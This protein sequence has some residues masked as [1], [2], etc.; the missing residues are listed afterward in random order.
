MI[1]ILILAANPKDTDPLR[2]GEEVRAIR[3]RLRLA[4]LRDQFVVEQE[5]AVRVTDLQGHLL[6]HKPHVVHFGGHGS[7]AEEIILEDV[8]GQSRP[9]SPGA[10]KRT[11]EVPKDN[12]RCVVLNAC[13]TEA[14]AKGIAESIDCVVGMTRAIGDESAI[15]FAAS[16]YQALG[17]GRSVQ[18]AFDLGCRQID[19]GG[20][21]DEDVPKLVIATGVDAK[22]V[23]LAGNVAGPPA[24][25]P[26]KPEPEAV[27]PRPGE[28]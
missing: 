13:Y 26:A 16:F 2:L 10:L 19:L 9:V 21:E 22:L 1:K 27:E 14:Q 12:I 17:Y 18:E 5:W 7:Q 20:L 6:Q 23:Y 4:E 8:K 15:A 11:F 3:E 28:P 24:N 25:E